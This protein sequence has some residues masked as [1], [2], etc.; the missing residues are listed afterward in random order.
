MREGALFGTTFGLGAGAVL[1]GVTVSRLV[2]GQAP[3]KAIEQ[4]PAAAVEMAPS[5]A[6]VETAPPATA[7]PSPRAVVPPVASP[8]A[9]IAT[10]GQHRPLP[11]KHRRPSADDEIAP[12]SAPAA[13]DTSP[14]ASIAEREAPT[15]APP[16]PR[17]EVMGAPDAREAPVA[18]VRG[19][20]LRPGMRAPGARI[21]QVEP[22]DR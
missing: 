12:R 13:S 15:A 1:V 4:P 17:A 14:T 19:G 11:R 18:I 10:A 20:L 2:V 5:A 8:P 9:E 6:V 7:E 16:P 22:Q 3:P 21:I